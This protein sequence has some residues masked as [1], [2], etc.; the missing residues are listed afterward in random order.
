MILVQ[1]R[2]ALVSNR[3]LPDD[4]ANFSDIPG[5]F[6]AHELAHQWWGQ[7][8]GPQ[9]YRERW[10]S[11]GWAQYAAALWIRKSRGDGVFRDVM[12]RFARWS[13]RFTE[14]GPIN[15]GHRLG[16]I[17]GDPQIYRAVVYDKGAWV[18]HMLRGLVG[19]E[20]FTRG[21]L[22]FQAAHRFDKAGTDDFREALE[23]A[24]G[25]DLKAYFEAWIYGTALPQIRYAWQLRNAGPRLRV[26]LRIDARDLPGPFPVQ[27]TIVGDGGRETRALRLPPRG[28]PFEIEV[29]WRPRRV[30]L[31]ADRSLL[32]RVDRV[33]F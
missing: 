26:A 12:D 21:V 33:N 28:G 24:S 27:I 11:E 30:E 16:H 25:Q 15:L 13:F 29:P 5:F 4:P 19:A 32:A 2:P 8:V 9:N 1:L 6:L 18:L 17:K 7:G 22:A 31:N 14:A 3:S 20:A 10:L 23:A